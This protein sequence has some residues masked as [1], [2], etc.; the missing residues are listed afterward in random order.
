MR[1]MWKVRGIPG[2]MELVARI[3]G[4]GINGEDEGGVY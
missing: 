4:F 3:K 1:D 2:W